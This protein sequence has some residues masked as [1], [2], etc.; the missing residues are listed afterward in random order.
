MRTYSLKV[1]VGLAQLHVLVLKK[2]KKAKVLLVSGK[3]RMSC[4]TFKSFAV[5]VIY[6][7]L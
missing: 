2:G 4:H 7:K 1:G 6:F 3:D 5:R